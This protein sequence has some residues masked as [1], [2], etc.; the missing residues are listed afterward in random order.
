MTFRGLNEETG[1]CMGVGLCM[2]M[3]GGRGKEASRPARIVVMSC[4]KE[5]DERAA[6][7]IYPHD[8]AA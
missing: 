6:Q 4:N 5:D 8:L 1:L 3:W 2:R 7:R